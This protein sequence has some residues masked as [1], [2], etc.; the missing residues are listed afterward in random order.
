V[1]KVLQGTSSHQPCVVLFFHGGKVCDGDSLVIARSATIAKCIKGEM[2]DM[3][4]DI[5]DIQKDLIE[6]THWKNG[7]PSYW[8]KAEQSRTYY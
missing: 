7:E 6:V 8:H 1:F 4:S 2:D 5:F 3:L